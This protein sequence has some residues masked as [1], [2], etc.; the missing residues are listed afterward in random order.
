M[1]LGVDFDGTIANTK[2]IVLHCLELVARADS[3]EAL[4]NFRLHSQELE[5][6]TL[7]GQLSSFIVKLELEHAKEMYMEIYANIGI[8]STTLIDGAREL[9]QFCKKKNYLIYIISAKS[10]INLIKSLKFLNLN[11]D[12]YVGGLDVS[13]K[14]KEIRRLNIQ[15]Y[16][17]DQISDAVAGE[18][19]GS[20]PV[21]LDIHGRLFG[22][23]FAKVRSIWEF[24]KIISESK[25]K[26]P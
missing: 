8:P 3:A 11:P 15:Y 6:K 16:L 13:G 22:H 20:I 19:G 26:N 1:N 12:G 10:E 5:G 23:R 2:D 24:M 25:I 21:L 17:G 7:Q 9:F 18:Q 4:L 14:A